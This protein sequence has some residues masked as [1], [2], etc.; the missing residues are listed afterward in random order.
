MTNEFIPNPQ[1]PWIDAR[2][3]QETIC[4]VFKT[5]PAVALALAR[6]FFPRLGQRQLDGLVAGTARLVRGK[7]G[8]RF[9]WNSRS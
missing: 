2:K 8:I 1:D 5:D 3:M 6:K 4:D 7:R 9:E